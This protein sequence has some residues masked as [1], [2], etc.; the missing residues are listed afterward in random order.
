MNC[1][2][3]YL[4]INC[5][6]GRLE[7]LDALR[8]FLWYGKDIPSIAAE[9]WYIGF[10]NIGIDSPLIIVGDTNPIDRL[11]GGTGYEDAVP[12]P[13]AVDGD[14]EESSETEG[15]ESARVALSAK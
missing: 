3:Q 8:S 11:W 2:W 9:A 5:F 6:F 7:R 12:E 10:T 4:Q 13:L 15:P 1:L 14:T